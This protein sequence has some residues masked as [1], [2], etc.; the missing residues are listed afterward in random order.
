MKRSAFTMIELI[1]VIVIL[2]ILA[3]VAIP[4]LSSVKDDAALANAAQTFCSDA[5]K[6][7]LGV[8]SELRPSGIGGVDLTEIVPIKGNFEI[9]NADGKS[10]DANAWGFT[11]SP[12]PTVKNDTSNI[13]VY[14]FDANGTYGNEIGC[15]VS[16][17]DGT[18]ISAKDMNDTYHSE[19]A[20]LFK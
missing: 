16:N 15:I 1:F 12:T 19:T 11:G 4:K 18:K 2:G 7:K 9:N 5:V 20:I 17:D 8:I 14:Y 6:G 3:A 13:F 10:I